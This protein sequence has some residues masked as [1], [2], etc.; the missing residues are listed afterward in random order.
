MS[1]VV[2]SQP[3]IGEGGALRALASQEALLAFAI[4]AVAILVGLYNPR[5]LATRNLADI[6][7]GNAYIAVAAI[8]MSMVIVSGNIDISV[9]S[10]IGVLATISGSLAVTG[11]PIILVWLTPLVVGI[12][13]MM[14]QGAVIAYLR[15]PAIVVTLG[16]LSILKGGLIS[17]TGGRWITDL[18]Q[19]FHLAD[20]ELFGFLPM[21]VLIMVT[22]TVLA[23]LWMRYS[24][25]G[26]AIYATGG[27]AEA[28][29]L[30]GVSPRRT[31]V[32]VFALHGFFAGVAALLF[33]TQ[34]KVIQSTVPPNLELTVITASV[35]GGVS[36]LGGTGT[37]IGSTLA[38]ILFATIGSSLIFLNVSA[39]W[40]RA[41][42]GLMILATVLADMIR[43]RRA[44]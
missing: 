40:L 19:G 2:V 39:Y 5:F 4:L 24:A 36:I 12:L 15:I 3:R 43:R 16:M 31:V 21:P 18:P 33:A 26:R 44:I 28:A 22:A 38:A 10:L 29:R 9:G 1:T 17:V 34:L 32:M 23:A 25:N 13:V 42:L 6:V 14:L 30:C 35:I 20:I 11:V 27:N 37:V 7:L 41:V 8:G